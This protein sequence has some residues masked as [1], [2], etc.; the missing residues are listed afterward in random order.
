VAGTGS[1]ASVERALAILH[2]YRDG[3]RSLAVT[4]VATELGVANSTAHRLLRSL[5]N[6]GFLQQEPASKR[7]QL[8]LLLYRLG[9]LAVTHSD[10]YRCAFAPL[11]R[12][13]HA[14]GEGCH[15]SVLDPPD[16]VYVEH[17]DS[18]R[19]IQFIARMGVRAPANCTSTGKIL[20]AHAPAPVV[21]DVLARGL[22]RLTPMSIT[23]PIALAEE[24]AT[25]RERGYAQSRDESE[26]GTTS[27]AAPVRD[28]GGTVIAALGIA[29]RTSRMHRLTLG[30]LVDLVLACSAEISEQLVLQPRPRGVSF[31]HGGMNRLPEA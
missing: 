26:I 21:E 28:G 27:V 22:I 14:T 3:R 1:V 9:N 25:V 15:V 8:S 24:L 2:L 31:P 17:R 20:L 23:D 29:G 5:C 16:V 13:H 18:D 10:L 7:Y 19:T 6:G 12:L 11:E 30:R 4:E